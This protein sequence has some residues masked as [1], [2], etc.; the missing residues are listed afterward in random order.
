M[1]CRDTLCYKVLSAK[2][3]PEGDVLRS[4]RTDKPSFMWKTI[5]KVASV[6][7]DGFGWNVGNGRKIDFW[8]ENWGFESLSGD[9]I[10]LPRREV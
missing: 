7:Y 1:C 3:F 10:C 9:S 8:N 4:K 2:Y 5:A 6:L